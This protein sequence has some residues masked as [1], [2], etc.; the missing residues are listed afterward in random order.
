[1]SE[2]CPKWGMSEQDSTGLLWT[3]FHGKQGDT[4][5]RIASFT[6]QRE[7]WEYI[8]QEKRIAELNDENTRCYAE[9][10]EKMRKIHS[11]A[12]EAIVCMRLRAE[13]AEKERDVV[14]EA[15]ALACYA[16]SCRRVNQAEWMEGLIEKINV[17]ARALD[18]PSRA[19]SN[20]DGIALRP[21]LV[22]RGEYEGKHVSEVPVEALQDLMAQLEQQK[23]VLPIWMETFRTELM[24]YLARKGR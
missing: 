17:L 23:E 4:R 13:Q 5:H 3:V 8:E 19:I 2:K 21:L 1:M 9:I 22:L 20:F 7:A 16:A 10:A 14:K 15:E 24:H 11:E 12:V 6:H 18:D